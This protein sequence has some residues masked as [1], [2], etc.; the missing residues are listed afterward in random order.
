MLKAINVIVNGSPFSVPAGATVA[1]AVS[2]AKQASRI[3]VSGEPRSSLCGMGVC[4]E[5]RVIIN[6]KP[7]CRSCQIL[8]EAGMDVRTD[9]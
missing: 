6:G 3:S 8:C 9:E 1:V 4:Q 2:I 5:C 7:H